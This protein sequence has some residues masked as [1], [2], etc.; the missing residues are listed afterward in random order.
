MIFLQSA[1]HKIAIGA[2]LENDNQVINFINA[3]YMTWL[4][5]RNWLI[6]HAS[7]VAA[8]G[9]A[10]AISAFS[11]G[12]K[13]TLMLHLL[14]HGEFSY[15]TNDRLFI[16]KQSDKV[17]STG[18]PKLPRINP[19]TIVNNA[20]LASL[21]SKQLRNRYLNM[22]VEQLWELEEKYDVDIEK[23]YGKGRIAETAKLS[24]LLVL[25]WQR[26][27]DMPLTVKR[28]DLK[29][30]EDLLSAIMK[31]PGPFYQYPSGRFITDTEFPDT[32]NY[33]DTLD[34]T[35]IYEASGRVDFP[36]LASICK[37]QLI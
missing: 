2:C 27:S 20:K 36:V 30:R 10:L 9:R 35:P 6:C 19:G 7:A 23:T 24:S 34:K 31:S 29:Q 17:Y 18:I 1:A 13:S 37:E 15:L 14:D 21:I 25:N 16:R 26:K 4:Q 28:V 8:N 22:P 11:G 12:G 33:L 5:H 32:R 3:Q